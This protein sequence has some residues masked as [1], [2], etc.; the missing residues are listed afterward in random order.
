MLNWAMTT[1]EWIEAAHS[2]CQSALQEQ[3]IQDVEALLDRAGISASAW[4]E[5]LESTG[6]SHSLSPSLRKLSA[7]VPSDSRFTFERKLLLDQAL[8]SLPKIA[9][10]P[11][12]ETV[13]QLFCK[14]FM[15]MAEPSD[16]ALPKFSV[17]GYTFLAMARL[18]LL[19][20]FP[21]GH[22]HWEVSGF[23][24]AWLP[25]VPL[26]LLP[27][28]LRFLLLEARGMKPW[29]VSHMRG[30]GAGNPFLVESEFRKS[31]FRMALALEKQPHIQA[32]MA[33][34]WL[35][36][37]ETHRVSPHLAF[38]NRIFVEAGGIVTDLGP[39]GEEDGFATGNKQRAEL[40]RSGLYKPTV[41]VAM[42]SRRQVIAWA[43]KHSKLEGQLAV[44]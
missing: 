23:P 13:K 15:F 25:K 30:T 35:H 11:V 4:L 10:L 21:A 36:S 9:A 20:R 12:D 14:E 31:F 18:V 38:L 1:Q 7:S 40:Y 42:C 26:R 3:G 17:D 22:Y 29:F 44:K 19:E 27:V 39:A 6:K 5:A 43:R 8:I 33:Q 32:V 2:R 24:R 37:P 28:T 41:G 16:D 34:S